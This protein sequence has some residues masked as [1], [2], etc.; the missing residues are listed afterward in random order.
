MEGPPPPSLK[1]LMLQVWCAVLTLT[2]VVMATLLIPLKSKSADV[3]VL[4]VP[5]F[6]HFYFSVKNRKLEHDGSWVEDLSCASCSLILKNNSIYCNRTGSA[7]APYFIYAQVVFK[8]S[9]QARSVT[10]IR[11][12]SSSGKSQR[13][14]VEV[15]APAEG[16]VWLG[17]IIKLTDGESISL[18]IHGEYRKENTFWGGFQLP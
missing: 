11:N 12:A 1:V 5:L 8:K 3:S 6:H 9:G 18:Q 4:P 7:P 10:L 16:S 15:P 14:L 17:K 2:L 13:N